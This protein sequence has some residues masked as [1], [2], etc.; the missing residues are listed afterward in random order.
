MSDPPELRMFLGLFEVGARVV[1]A[2][3]HFYWRRRPRPHQCPAHTMPRPHQCPRPYTG[4]SASSIRNTCTA[5]RTGNV[6][7]SHREFRL[8]D[9]FEW[10]KFEINIKMWRKRR[11]FR[12]TR[13][14]RASAATRGRCWNTSRCDSSF[15]FGSEPEVGLKGLCVSISIY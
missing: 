15:L 11:E 8:L 5:T 6:C 12:N 4:T 7:F 9:V 14:P 3:F 2:R 13:S 1:S 10:M